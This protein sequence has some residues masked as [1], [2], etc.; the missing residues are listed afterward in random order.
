MQHPI[1]NLAILFTTLAI[2]ACMAVVVVNVLLALV[3][4]WVVAYAGVSVLGFG[5]SRWTSDIPINYFRGV[6]GIALKLM[7]MTPLI[8]VAVVIMDGFY[9]DMQEGHRCVSY[10]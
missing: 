4:A 2:L 6:A 7:T 8:G 1:D 5:G 3:T 10:W 9:R